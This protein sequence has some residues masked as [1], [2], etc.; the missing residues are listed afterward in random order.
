MAEDK[1]EQRR[2]REHA[3]TEALNRHGYGFQ[4]SVLKAADDFFR[5]TRDW[6]PGWYPLVAEY[7][8]ELQGK[9]TRIDFIL[10]SHAP[11][12]G[13][14]IFLIC[15]CKRVNPAFGEWCFFRAPFVMRR[16]WGPN[17]LFAD[18][19]SISQTGGVNVYGVVGRNIEKYRH[20]LGLELKT[21]EKGDTSGD[22]PGAIEEVM[23]QVFRGVNGYIESLCK[24]QAKTC[25]A[26]MPVVFTT[27]RLYASDVQLDS[28]DI[29]T[30]EVPHVDREQ[31]PWVVLQYH[32]SPGLKHTV[33][34]RLRDN[35]DMQ[36]VLALEFIRSVCIVNGSNVKDFLNEF[37]PDDMGFGPIDR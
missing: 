22:G 21:R 13:D 37:R 18:K 36:D 16:P 1:D 4:Y 34:P 6:D 35:A 33:E 20:N 26:L 19:V 31:V 28:A 11:D 2:Q 8:V 15:E 27:A 9:S 30:G 14:P 32:V 24:Y 17:R 29:K 25:Q 23:G 3:L 5:T 10:Q 7:P 12:G